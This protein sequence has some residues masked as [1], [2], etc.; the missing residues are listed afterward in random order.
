MLHVMRFMK[1]IMLII[2][3]KPDYLESDERIFE[4]VYKPEM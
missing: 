4:V 3:T 1:F 2:N